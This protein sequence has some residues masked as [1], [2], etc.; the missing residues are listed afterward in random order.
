M[1]ELRK[2]E[3][4]PGFVFD[5]SVAGDGAAPLVL[6]LHGFAVSRHLYD[7]QVPALGRLTWEGSQLVATPRLL[8]G[9]TVVLAGHR[10]AGKTRLLPLVGRLLGRTG[11]DLD[12]VVEFDTDDD[13]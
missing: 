11:L 7:A 5:V 12:A 13:E 8:T 6:L 4:K 10:T 2:I 3:T 9:Q 1:T